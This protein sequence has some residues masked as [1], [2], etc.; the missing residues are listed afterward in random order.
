[1]SGFFSLISTSPSLSGQ[2][3][4]RCVTLVNSNATLGLNLTIPI[5][6][7]VNIGTDNKTTFTYFF[8]LQQ[9][10]KIHKGEFR[11]VSSTG[12]FL[13]YDQTQI[14]NW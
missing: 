13:H 1:M 14:P 9:K 4:P 7:Q 11:R 8:G 2:Y 10:H 5:S 6:H 12:W 3:T